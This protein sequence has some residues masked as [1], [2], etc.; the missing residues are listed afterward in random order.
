[1]ML[2]HYTPLEQFDIIAILPLFKLANLYLYIT[3][4]T[5]FTIITGLTLVALLHF[6]HLKTKI[7]PTNWQSIIEEVYL[8]TKTLVEKNIGQ[9]GLQFFPLIFF[10]FSFLVITNLI[11]MIPYSFTI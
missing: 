5:I 11:G 8:F 9:G 7:V 3:N 2:N 6:I 4:S 10:L 1:M